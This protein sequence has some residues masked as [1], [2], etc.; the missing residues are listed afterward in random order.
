VAPVA[1]I[2]SAFLELTKKDNIGSDI[3]LPRERK[4]RSLSKEV[5][6]R[7]FSPWLECTE[8]RFWLKH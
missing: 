3:L 7:I 5:E 8:L 6:E 2:H 1:G 4:G